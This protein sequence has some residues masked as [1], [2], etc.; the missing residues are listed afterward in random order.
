MVYKYSVTPNPRHQSKTPLLL[1]I[2]QDSAILEKKCYPKFTIWQMYCLLISNDTLM[3]DKN[4]FRFAKVLVNRQKIKTN[5]PTGT[6][7][8]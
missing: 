1:T 2:I 7:L 5:L 8:Y 3:S 4:P 6:F